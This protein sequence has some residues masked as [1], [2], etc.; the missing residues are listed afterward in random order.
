[1]HCRV[2]AI[3]YEEG[4]EFAKSRSL[5][6]L[7]TSAKTAENVDD[8]FIKTAHKVYE[9]IRRGVFDP[10]DEVKQVPLTYYSLVV[11][12]RKSC[13]VFFFLPSMLDHR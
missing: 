1:V 10:N 9:Q 11:S 13:N 3:S 12:L 2:F 5:I 8:A 7:E 4:M 6:F